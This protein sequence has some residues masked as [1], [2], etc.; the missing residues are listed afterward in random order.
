MEMTS[1]EVEKYLQRDDIILIPTG[2]NER[3][4]R[5]LP[6]GHKGFGPAVMIEVLS[7]VL[8]GA[9]IPGE[10]GLWFWDTAVPINNGH[11]FMALDIRPF[12]DLD[13]FTPLA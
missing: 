11:F 8:S 9:G 4:S 6:L 12:C 3:H 2:S 1:L 13:V 5:H 10:M 7:G